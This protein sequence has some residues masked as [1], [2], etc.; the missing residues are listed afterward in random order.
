LMTDKPGGIGPAGRF[1]GSRSCT[2]IQTGVVCVLGHLLPIPRRTAGQVTLRNGINLT[3]R[4]KPR[5]PRRPG[6]RPHVPSSNQQCQRADA[7]AIPV[8][9]RASC[10]RLKEARCRG[11]PKWPPPLL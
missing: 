8:L 4:P 9:I 6:R 5:G 2:N 7:P 3:D 1:S 10:D 11:G